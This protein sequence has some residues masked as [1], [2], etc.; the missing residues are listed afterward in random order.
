MLHEILKRAKIFT[1]FPQDCLKYTHSW[2]VNKL[3]NILMKKVI[4]LLI[5]R[6][7]QKQLSLKCLFLR[8]SG[9]RKHVTLKEPQQSFVRTHRPTSTVSWAVEDCS[10]SEEMLDRIPVCRSVL[11]SC[12]PN[13]VD[14]PTRTIRK[15]HP[16][17]TFTRFDGRMHELHAH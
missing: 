17:T 8:V 12:M 15:G 16:D 5:M 7:I 1:T 14:C 10:H 13:V 6:I 11:F 2:T 9:S 4:H 3:F